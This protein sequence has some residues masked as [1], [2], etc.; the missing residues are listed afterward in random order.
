MGDYMKSSLIGCPSLMPLSLK[1]DTLQ[2][3]DK[4]KSDLANKS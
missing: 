2:E 1:T 4:K 3:S